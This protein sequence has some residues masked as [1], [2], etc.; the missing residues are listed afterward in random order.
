[1]AEIDYRHTGG[2]TRETAHATLETLLGQERAPVG[3]LHPQDWMQDARTRAVVRALTAGGAEVRFVGGC[4]RDALLHKAIKDIDIAT[5]ETPEVVIQRL[6]DAGLKAVPT[7]LEHGTVTA[8]ADGLSIEVTTLRRDVKTDGRHA[9]VAFTTDFREDA[10][11]RDFTMNALSATP[12]GAVF[13]YFDGLS[14]LAARVVRF[15]G[16]PHER[17]RE[18]YLRILRFFRFHAH[19]G[20]G[21]AQAEA[22]RACRANAAGLDHLSGERVRDELLKILDAPDPA[23]VLVEMRGETVL[24]RILPEA[25]H[26]DSLRV[27][28]WLE[29]SGLRRPGVEPDALRRLAALVAVDHDG[30]RALAERLKLSNADRDRLAAL[31]APRTDDPEPDPAADDHGLRVQTYRLGPERLRDR[32]LI[33]W[34]GERAGTGRLDSARTARWMR[35]MDVALDWTPP[36]PP[37]RGRDILNLGVPPGPRVGDLVRTAEDAWIDSDFRADRQS[38]LQTLRSRL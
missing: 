8:V 9:E 19:Y 11:R 20:E 37:V 33:L 4:V 28:S 25:A 31:A 30:A 14:D 35:L 22:L 27:L 18:D 5:Q 10:A 2:Q 1:M 34:A 36:S 29:T 16:R 38:L 13:D 3:Q 24:D 23:R 26:F 32:A 21:A 17:I 7:G 6:Q 15:V 12:D